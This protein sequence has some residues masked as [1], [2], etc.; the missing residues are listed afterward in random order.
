MKPSPSK[1]AKTTGK[2]RGRE[3]AAGTAAADV[4]TAARSEP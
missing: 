4:S 2:K 1:S 3:E